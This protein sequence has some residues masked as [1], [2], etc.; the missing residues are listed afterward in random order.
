LLD[1]DDDDSAAA[2]RARL[3][4]LKST[5]ILTD[6]AN[7]P[8]LQLLEDL[9]LPSHAPA[10]L[11]RS[12]STISSDRV[13]F[14]QT[15]P[16]I[17]DA[18]LYT[19]LHS[20]LTQTALPRAPPDSL[21]DPVSGIASSFLARHRFSA[22]SS[23][24]SVFRGAITG[25]PLSGKSTLLRRCH[26]A[27]VLDLAVSGGWKS[28][29]VF[30]LDMRSL[31]LDQSFVDRVLDACAAQRPRVRRELPALRRHFR[32]GLAR[33]H[34]FRG[35]DA[36]VRGLGRA[37]GDP[38]GIP[39]FVAALVGL[40]VDLPRALGFA[41]V[42]LFVDNFD[43]G[44]V[45]VAPPPPFDADAPR[46]VVAEEAKRALAKASFVVVVQD[47][48]IMAPLADGDVDLRAG[49]DVMTAVGA[50]EDVGSR[51]GYDYVMKIGGIGDGVRVAVEM[52]GGVPG[53]IAAWDELNHTLFRCERMAEGE[54][55]KE[56]YRTIED[57]QRLVDL[58]FV[59]AEGERLAV[60]GVVREKRRPGRREG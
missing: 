36:V 37:W 7:L 39:A 51:A 22:S 1:D 48:R 3:E 9:L 4:S 45:T 42:A 19:W 35:A 18:H 41:H 47:L 24:F 26:D 46:A 43:A 31:A 17:E 23:S 30:A 52:C 25:P 49:I 12:L 50:V 60:E 2:D 21:H 57:A 44:D 28:T 5:V 53:F 8:L 56:K 15:A 11:E 59:H 33:G 38:R 40:A 16:P 54:R 55:E 27:L 14:L 34:S 32:S 10:L 13:H 29:F 58:L 20:A 6:A